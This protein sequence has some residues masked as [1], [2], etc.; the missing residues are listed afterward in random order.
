MSGM[1]LPG[2]SPLSRTDLP[3]H[4]ILS[5]EGGPRRSGSAAASDGEPT[6]R[7]S[8]R[9]SEQQRT[10]LPSSVIHE[11]RT[12]LTSI[13][14]YA[15]VLQRSLRE[16][17]RAAN[18]LAVVVRESTRLSTML[19]ALSELAEIEAG[20]VPGSVGETHVGEIAEGVAEDIRQLDGDRHEIRVEGDAVARCNPH[21]LGRA[22]AHVLTNATLY[23]EPGTPIEVCVQQ[24]GRAAEIHVRDRG[25]GVM[26][27]DRFRI[28][29][30]FERG[31][32]ARPAG[33][34]GLGL[35][36]FLA[37]RSLEHVGGSIDHESGH[38]QTTFRIMLPA[39]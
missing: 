8:A 36:L 15:Q 3:A 4:A 17:K 20:D 30:A 22:L 31:V 19:E 29:E 21:L 18:A 13:H 27:A 12:P 26:P 7:R 24:N 23:S 16:D 33:V 2:V 1:D 6:A 10:G 28:Y 25:I 32:N 38:G 34:R 35:G 9:S 39:R 11:L 14:G 37:C 5:V